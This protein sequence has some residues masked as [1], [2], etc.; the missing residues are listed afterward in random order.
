MVHGF[1]QEP[2]VSVRVCLI[3]SYWPDHHVHT[4]DAR[5]CTCDTCQWY[6]SILQRNAWGSN[7]TR[8]EPIDIG[9]TDL[10]IDG[11]L[12][13][14]ETING[15]EFV[16]EKY[17]AYIPIS[18]WML[19]EQGLIDDT[20]PVIVPTRWQI[21]KRRTS[22]KVAELRI[23]LGSWIAGVQITDDDEDW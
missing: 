10:N 8:S 3:C 20:R 12:L 14:D 15:L 6:R 7:V 18:E 9:S 4:G 17:G 11:L 19:M 16:V 23:R 13:N 2:N 22:Q 1:V 21:I 5:Y